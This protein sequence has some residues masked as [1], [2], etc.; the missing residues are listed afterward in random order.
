MFNSTPSNYFEPPKFPKK[1][2]SPLSW[3]KRA[4]KELI[5][6]EASSQSVCFDGTI[7]LSYP[8]VKKAV[9]LPFVWRMMGINKYAR[10]G[11]AH[12]Q[13]A[14]QMPKN[15]SKKI[16]PRDSCSPYSPQWFLTQAN[17]FPDDKV[18]VLRVINVTKNCRNEVNFWSVIFQSF[19]KH[20][21]R[22]KWIAF[23]LLSQKGIKYL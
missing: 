5:S 4:A 20:R 7:I 6:L 14:F 9:Q 15:T 2:V 18:F 13:W 10:K 22:R 1:P 11:T 12:T 16:M 3:R 21:K 19:P 8:S 23:S 17:S